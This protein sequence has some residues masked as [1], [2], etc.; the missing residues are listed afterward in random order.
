[1][2]TVDFSQISGWYQLVGLIIVM[3]IAPNIKDII[4]YFKKQKQKKAGD[5][6]DLHQEIKKFST[7][8][9]AL[10]LKI[11][12]HIKSEVLSKEETNKKL[13]ELDLQSMAN[14]IITLMHYKPNEEITIENLCQ[15]Y[16]SKGGNGYVKSAYE[17]WKKEKQV[18]KSIQRNV[19]KTS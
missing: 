6:V 7:N 17:S 15:K 13:T 5:Y 14:Q 19:K 11:D 1:M 3:I 4:G 10:T 9:E 12:G 8:Q 2:Q 16:F 18:N